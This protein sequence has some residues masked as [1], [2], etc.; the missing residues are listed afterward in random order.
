MAEMPK[1][2]ERFFGRRFAPPSPG[3]RRKAVNV[4]ATGPESAD[5]QK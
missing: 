1:L 5:L 2:Q 4:A 3:G